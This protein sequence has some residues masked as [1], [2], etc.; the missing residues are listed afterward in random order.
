[1]S[2]IAWFIHAVQVFLDQIIL[3]CFVTT[4]SLGLYD[5]LVSLL[6]CSDA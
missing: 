3:F 2:F 1:M 5:A 6:L 4:C